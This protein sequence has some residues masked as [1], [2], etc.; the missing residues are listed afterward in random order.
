[1]SKTITVTLA[2]ATYVQL[3]EYAKRLNRPLNEVVE[4]LVYEH[5]TDCLGKESWEERFRNLLARVHSRTAQYP[6][7]EIEADITAA[8]WEI[9]RRGY[10]RQ[11]VN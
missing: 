4:E 8:A 6:S 11:R 7:E 5:L 9:K 1:M 10:G 3:K 2:D